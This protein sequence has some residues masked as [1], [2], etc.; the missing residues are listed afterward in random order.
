[1]EVRSLSIKVTEE[2]RALYQLLGGELNQNKYKSISLNKAY[3]EEPLVSHYI[4]SMLKLVGLEPD[5]VPADTIFKLLFPHETDDGGYERQGLLITFAFGMPD[6]GPSKAPKEEVDAYAKA[7]GN[8]WAAISSFK[9]VSDVLGTLDYD[10]LE[11][12]LKHRLEALKPAEE[13]AK[14][15]AMKKALAV[16]EEMKKRFDETGTIGIGEEVDIENFM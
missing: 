10:D 12:V 1:M 9:E 15:G 6:K 4:N 8:L 11:Q 5:L 16:K 3:V 2:L 14:E 7:L 13:R